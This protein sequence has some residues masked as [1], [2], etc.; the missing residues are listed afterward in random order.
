MQF[1]EGGG[2]FAPNAPSWIRHCFVHRYVKKEDGGMVL[3]FFQSEA[4]ISGLDERNE[5]WKI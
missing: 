4:S 5:V 3:V 2:A 1:L